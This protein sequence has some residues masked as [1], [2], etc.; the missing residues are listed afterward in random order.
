MAHARITRFENDGTIS[1][2]DFA[3]P[4]YHTKRGKVFAPAPANKGTQR[5]GMNRP[6]DAG[7]GRKLLDEALGD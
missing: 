5:D 1:V 7:A 4:T 3:E 2:Q 6:L